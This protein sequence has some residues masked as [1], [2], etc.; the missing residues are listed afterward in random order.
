MPYVPT[1]SGARYHYEVYGGGGEKVLFVAGFAC[2]KGY[3]KAT[4]AHLLKRGRSHS[5]RVAPSLSPSPSP[6]RRLSLSVPPSLPSSA[7]SPC[8]LSS[9]PSTPSA[10][11][12]PNRYDICVFDT[13]GFGKTSAGGLTR[14][15]TTT[16]AVDV[17]AILCHLGWVR[18]HPD[19]P[20]ATLS[21]PN[22]SGSTSSLSTPPPLHIVSW[23]LGGMVCQE[24]SF[25]L[26]SPSSLLSHSLASLVF[27]S[28]SPGGYRD[29]DEA[30]LTYALRNQPPWSG[31]KKIVRVMTALTTK[32]RLHWLLRLHYGDEYLDAPYEGVW[33]LPTE[34]EEAFTGADAGERA[35]V[36]AMGKLERKEDRREDRRE[37]RRRAGNLSDDDG[38]VDVDT[39]SP[40]PASASA[41]TPVASPVKGTGVGSRLRNR[42]VLVEVYGTRSPFDRH[43]VGYL[44]SLAHHVLAVYTHAFSRERFHLLHSY[45]SLL[46]ASDAQ[47]KTFTRTTTQVTVPA[48]LPPPALSSVASRRV[49][50]LVVVGDCDEL[51]A[52]QNSVTLAKYLRC[53][54]LIFKGSGHMVYVEHAAVYGDVLHRHF[55]MAR[56]AGGRW[57]E[58]E[59]IKVVDYTQGVGVERGG[60]RLST[61]SATLSSGRGVGEGGEGKGG[62]RWGMTGWR[63]LL[64]CFFVWKLLSS[65]PMWQGMRPARWWFQSLREVLRPILMLYQHLRSLMWWRITTCAQWLQ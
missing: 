59:C 9:P 42:D 63:R 35:A 53:P 46:P 64:T 44:W 7:S 31:F 45:N 37:E 49:H 32:S 33:P 12:S 25:L 10:L 62:G 61:I 51:I 54:A 4:V 21:P 30:A 3:W 16:M 23:S 47:P 8:S 2:C 29:P 58:D 52:P 57:Y 41:V 17:L 18:P 5:D 11:S 60:R 38:N 55:G 15:S 28:S 56:G 22:P 34:F 43:V 14:Y 19:S 27:T 48:A 39:P 65:L 26:L 24:L 50:P 40:R 13:R 6:P 36:R 20:Y 1:P